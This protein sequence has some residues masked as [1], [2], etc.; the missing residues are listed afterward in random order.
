MTIHVLADVLRITRQIE[1]DIAIAVEE[2]VEFAPVLERYGDQCL[3][4]R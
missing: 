4:C 3:R 2:V 1:A